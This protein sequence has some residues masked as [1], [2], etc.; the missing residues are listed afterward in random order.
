MNDLFFFS[1]MTI[2]Q[3]GEKVHMRQELIFFRATSN[4]I[5]QGKT[6]DPD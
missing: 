2:S 3:S 6:A 4:I 1:R 5:P